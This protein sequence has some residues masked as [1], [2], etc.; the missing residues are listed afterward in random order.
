MER[1]AACVKRSNGQEKLG[2]RSLEE[3]D[4]QTTLRNAC[5]L[6]TRVYSCSYSPLRIQV[7]HD[8]VMI[9]EHFSRNWPLRKS[10]TTTNNDDRGS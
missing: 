9:R 3:V 7:G 8:N 4:I 6:W 2:F 10:S 5:E 1:Y